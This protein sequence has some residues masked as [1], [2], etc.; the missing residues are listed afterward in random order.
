M[1]IVIG[2]GKCIPGKQDEVVEA[3]MWMQDQSRR[4]PGCVRY[5]FHFAVEDPD[6]FVAV[7]VWESAAALREH[8]AAPSVAGFAERIGGLLATPPEVRIHGVSRTNDFP[9][10]EGLE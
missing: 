2:R 10:L 3:L 5:G 8:F 4:E 7:E 9:D 6:S 1:L